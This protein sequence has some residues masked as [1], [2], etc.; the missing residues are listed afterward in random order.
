MTIGLILC[1]S[2]NQI[3]AEYALRDNA[4]PVGGCQKLAPEIVSPGIACL[5][6]ELFVVT[7]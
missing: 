7:V 2:K 5:T 1:M 3:A 6:P 4:R